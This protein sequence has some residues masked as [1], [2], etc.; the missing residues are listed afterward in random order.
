MQQTNKRGITSSSFVSLIYE[1]EEYC[2]LFCR[3]EF[4][5]GSIYIY[6]HTTLYVRGEQTCC[7]RLLFVFWCGR[8]K[9]RGL[10]LVRC[11]PLALIF[12]FRATF[13]TITWQRWVLLPGRRCRRRGRTLTCSSRSLRTNTLE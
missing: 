2:C 9:R 11:Q 6:V 10:P 3:R 8:A 7:G 1:E 13:R 4:S 12:T 5:W